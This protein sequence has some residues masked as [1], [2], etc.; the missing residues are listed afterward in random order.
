VTALGVLLAAGLAQEPARF[1]RIESGQSEIHRPSRTGAA[2]A[3]RA[4]RP[5]E[6]TG[7]VRV[8]LG[9]TVSG[10]DEGY[11]TAELGLELRPFAAARVTPV[12]GAGAG[13]LAEPEFSGSVLRGTVAVEVEL[14]TRTA[15]RVGYQAAGHGGER[16]PNVWFVGFEVRGRQRSPPPGAQRATD[17]EGAVLELPASGRGQ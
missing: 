15:A 2:V 6:R 12:V 8:E 7:V 11:V 3:L 1:V 13:I 17:A 9:A 16:G 10:A 5:L 14:T 4:G